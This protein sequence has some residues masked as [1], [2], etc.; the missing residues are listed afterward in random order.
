MKIS[1]LKI[2]KT[3]I[4]PLVLAGGLS[5]GFTGCGKT[6]NI[7]MTQT[8]ISNLI[9]QDEI[10]TITSL[11]DL[12][13]DGVLNYNDELNEVE[14][15]DR[16]EK[17]MNSVEKIEAIK[18]VDFS[19]VSQL[20]KLNDNEYKESINYSEG[21]IDAL[22]E[23]AKYEGNDLIQWE[24]KLSAVKKL[25][26]IHTHC[27]EWIFRNGMNVSIDIMIDSVK[28]SL[29]AEIGIPT[30]DYKLIRIDAKP[31]NEPT[32]LKII[33]DE[34]EFYVNS[35]QKEIYDTID[36]IYTLQRIKNTDSK[37]KNEYETYKKALNYAKITIAAGSNLKNGDI[38][39]QNSESYIEENYSK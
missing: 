33:V 26:Y 37:P 23:Q 1:N 32:E 29:A 7:D 3:K 39:V 19:E 15:A 30:E 20:S 6:N 35:K 9:S 13:N 25:D 38:E 17:Y 27:K 21:E 18:D 34:K 5:L 24:N 31:S 4:T 2:V 12:V 8:T 16:L 10:K 14:A 11:D 22:I 28:A 36:Y